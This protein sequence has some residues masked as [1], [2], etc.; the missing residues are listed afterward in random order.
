[1]KNNN[2]KRISK[3]TVMKQYGFTEKMIT[4]YLPAPELATNPHY[5]SAP[6]MK[7]WYEDDVIRIA[8]EPEVKTKLD[9]LNARR[10]STGMKQAA[11]TRHDTNVIKNAVSKG[12]NP[13]AHR[14]TKTSV[15][16]E[17]NHNRKQIERMCE[18]PYPDWYP[19]ARN[20]HRK[21]ILHVGATNSGKTHDAL[22]ALK[23]AKSGVYLSPL[24]LLALEVGDDLRDAGIACNVITGEEQDL[25]T[26]AT[27]TACTIEMM[28]P[29]SKYD[30]AVIDEAQMIADENRGGS[31]TNAI[32]GVAAYE[33][34]V[35]MA[36]EALN[37]VKTLI[38]SCGDECTVVKHER[39]TEL[40]P[41][42]SP[43]HATASDI[44]TG[45]ALI[46]FS[47]RGV[48]STA[49]KLESQGVKTSMI[50]GALPW[51]VRKEEARKFREHETKVV[52]STDAI[53]MGLNLPIRRVIFTADSKY[54]GKEM[55]PLYADE[56][57][58]IA[59]RAGRYGI[60]PKGYV[61]GTDGY[62]ANHVRDGII[63][64]FNTIGKA[65]IGIPRELMMNEDIE[66]TDIIRAW[67]ETD[68]TKLFGGLNDCPFIR[69]NTDNMLSAAAWLEHADVNQ[70]LS[71]DDMISLITVQFDFTRDEQFE[72][73][74][75]LC[76]DYMHDGKLMRSCE[77]D[78]PNMNAKL[79]Y[80]EN[81]CHELAIM[82]SFAQ[83]IGIMDSSLNALFASYRN[84]VERRMITL[85]NG[86][87]QNL[88]PMIQRHF[89]Y[90]DD[91]DDFSYDRTMRDIRKDNFE[92]FKNTDEFNEIMKASSSVSGKPVDDI[93]ESFKTRFINEGISYAIEKMPGT[94]RMGNY[95]VIKNTIYNTNDKGFS[96]MN[97]IF[98]G[99]TLLNGEIIM[100]ADGNHYKI[101]K[102]MIESNGGVVIPFD[103]NRA[104]EANQIIIAKA[105][106]K[107][108]LSKQNK[109]KTI[110]YLS[111]ISMLNKQLSSN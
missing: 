90:Y 4:D 61:T 93:I 92:K 53:G 10:N 20:M 14:K 104:D 39:K 110:N 60:Y 33:I 100:V 35:C 59:G 21:F 99:S 106:H 23:T 36:P 96:R 31:W 83:H 30:V 28:E 72:L 91:W 67:N 101:I 88:A 52:V 65:M 58:Q 105:K 34:H 66:L 57:K 45:D 24:R 111:F 42:T 98:H 41:M 19:K 68:I 77:P 50:Y 103:M 108:A 76:R 8:Q 44:Q 5:R 3:T 70:V 49:A 86:S 7:L 16:R 43:I 84:R 32:I 81:Y 97:S 17:R 27:H 63:A 87:K 56:I 55:R 94:I 2:R 15:N 11:A 79:D 109:K 95:V 26:N 73:W 51:K 48:L 82:F 69:E 85:M 1:M 62:I 37:I 29:E 54:D 12:M 47:R 25:Q 89:N 13:M 107:K 40:I 64:G 38:E 102:K 22:E 74:S 6:K 71:R 75:S 18:Q 78:A 80:Y 9:A 46:A